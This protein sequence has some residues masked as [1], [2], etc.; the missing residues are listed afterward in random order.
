MVSHT[1]IFS[2]LGRNMQAYTISWVTTFFSSIVNVLWTV[3]V[4]KYDFVSNIDGALASQ[5]GVV[6]LNELFLLYS[7]ILSRKYL[8]G[9]L[10]GM[11][12][13]LWILLTAAFIFLLIYAPIAAFDSYARLTHVEISG[14]SPLYDQIKG[15]SAALL[16]FA[17]GLTHF[18]PEAL[19]TRYGA[20]PGLLLNGL[21]LVVALFF[22]RAFFRSR[23]AA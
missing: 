19:Q 7:V 15:Y 8:F 13:T 9:R 1:S 3:Y 5:I 23:K 6:C 21:S 14:H 17:G 16:G 2:L 10:G 11:I 4:F 18:D 22:L 20:M 12:N